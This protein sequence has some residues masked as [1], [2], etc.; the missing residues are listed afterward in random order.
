MSA[1]R[2]LLVLPRNGSVLLLKAGD[3]CGRWVAIASWGILLSGRQNL[4]WQKPCNPEPSTLAHPRESPPRVPPRLDD[5]YGPIRADILSRWPEWNAWSNRCSCSVFPTVSG[6][7]WVSMRPPT[8][9]LSGDA[10]R[11]DFSALAAPSSRT[12]NRAAHPPS[13]ASISTGGEGFPP[14]F[15]RSVRYRHGLS[16]EGDSQRQGTRA[17]AVDS[18]AR[19]GSKRMAGRLLC[20]YPTTVK[21]WPTGKSYGS[22]LPGVE[23]PG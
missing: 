21:A 10:E 23:R 6:A 4:F 7:S 11:K 12:A 15:G 3:A 13:F 17:S 14:R 20:L 9:S 1:G 18:V 22:W 19:A 16:L 5:P 8:V 2:Y